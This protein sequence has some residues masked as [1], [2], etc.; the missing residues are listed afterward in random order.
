V[1]LVSADFFGHLPPHVFTYELRTCGQVIWGD[2]SVL[3]LIPPI[4]AGEIDREDGWRLLANRIIE[5]LAAREEPAP[6]KAE[7]PRS[8]EYHTV[9]LFLDMATSLLVF[10]GDYA[11]TYRQRAERLGRLAARTSR[12]MPFP[13]PEFA[14]RVNEFTSWKLW[15]GEAPWPSGDFT[16][17]ARSYARALWRW[18]LQQLTGLGEVLDERV[19]M[20]RWMNAQPYRAR[21]RGWLSA[22]AAGGWGGGMAALPAVRGRAPNGYSRGHRAL[23]PLVP[24]GGPGIDTVALARRLPLAEQGSGHSAEALVRD[25]V[26]NYRDLLV[27]T[28]A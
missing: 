20:D 12:G 17:E 18:E 27:G 2:S 28:T 3:A 25:I 9:K 6:E 22:A 4:A 13:L 21:V 19:L 16:E 15:A 8:V 10:T 23:R 26:R 7:R 1:A 11:P 5:Q 14:R 24:A